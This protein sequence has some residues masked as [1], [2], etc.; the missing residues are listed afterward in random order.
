MN[1][2]SGDQ[3]GF[4]L[5]EASLVMT[6][7][8]PPF[9]EIVPMSL[10]PAFGGM[11]Q[12]AMRLPLGDHDGCIASF[13]HNKRLSP[14]STFAIHKALGVLFL[15]DGAPTCPRVLQTISRPSGDQAG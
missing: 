7:I 3:T 4:Q 9:R 6:S 11:N 2:P 13:S 15:D 5:V 14:V 10:L 8:A 1:L 12:N